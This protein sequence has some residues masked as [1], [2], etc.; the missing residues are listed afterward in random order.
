[1]E[2]RRPDPYLLFN[3]ETT[4]GQV[5]DLARWVVDSYGAHTNPGAGAVCTINAPTAEI[6]NAFDEEMYLYSLDK[7]R[8]L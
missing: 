3:P 7:Y 1:M 8:G 4:V 5:R 2:Y 6:Y